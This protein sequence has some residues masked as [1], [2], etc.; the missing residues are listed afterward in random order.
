MLPNH[1]RQLPNKHEML[2][3]QFLLNLDKARLVQ[4]VPGMKLPEIDLEELD[5]QKEK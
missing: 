4:K 1:I 3:R 2:L 5:R